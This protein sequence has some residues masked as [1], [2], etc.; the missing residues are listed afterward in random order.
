MTIVYIHSSVPSETELA[1]AP[2]GAAFR[3]ASFW[4]GEV[5]PAHVVYAD[6]EKIRAAYENAGVEAHVLTGEGEPSGG[7]P[8]EELKQLVGTRQ[9]NALAEGGFDSV[10]AAQE[11]AEDELTALDGVGASTFERLHGAE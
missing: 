7:K 9:A 11:L 2:D 5:E 4:H 1:G 6:S 8:S 10:E 3:N